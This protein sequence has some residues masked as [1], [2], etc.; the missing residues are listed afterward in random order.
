MKKLL[1]I[2]IPTYKRPETL[3]RCID[4][5]VSQIEKY[6]LSDCV[7]IYVTNDA[8]PDDTVSV[9]H[10][11]ASLSYFSGV[12]REQNLGMNVNIKCMLSEVA[13]KSDYQLIITDDDFLQ[14]DV[15]DS[16]AKFLVIQQVSNPDVPL[17]WT[18]RY[19]Y[20]EDGNL[21]CVVC[22]AFQRDTLIS[23]SIRNAGRYMYNG[24]VLSGLIVK[25]TEINF[26]FWSKYLENAYFPII[27]SGEVILRRP[28]L[29]WDMN[30]VRH[31]VLNECHWERWGQSEAEIT[32]RLF[33]DFINAYVVIGRKIRP[34]YRASLFY[35][36]AFPSITLV[37]NSLLSSGGFFHLNDSESTTLLNTDRVSFSKIESPA[38]IILFIAWIQVLSACLSKM[39]IFN[40]LLLI[41]TDRSKR[42]RRQEALVKYRQ[43][44]AN[45]AFM[46]R[47]TL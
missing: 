6:A 30:V 47:W 21:L 36:S 8:S 11:Y 34:A 38:G 28:S 42:K 16:V 1:T 3:R 2:C 22:R 12:T 44:L 31:T 23:P 43:M 13:K 41:T 37:M 24:F 10:A 15:L 35:A 9:L 4:S 32:L 20:T 39:A 29:F 40:I 26:P 5:I 14:P 45:A 19:S 17:I 25:S 7:D 46:L 27:F 33:I 18:P